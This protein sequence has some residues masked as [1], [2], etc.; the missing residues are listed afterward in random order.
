MIAPCGMRV[1]MRY[2]VTHA[3][4][5]REFQVGDRVRLMEN[6][7]ILNTAAQGWMPAEDVPSAT[8]GMVVAPD[9]DWAKAMRADLERRLAELE[10]K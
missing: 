9:A 1:G 10:G 4:K 2:V 7:D 8:R 6:G 3:S 5:N